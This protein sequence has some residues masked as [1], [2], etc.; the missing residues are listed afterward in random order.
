M[1]LY[2]HNEEKY[3]TLAIT[4][5]KKNPQV[6]TGEHIKSLHIEGPVPSLR[7]ETS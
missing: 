5:A 6:S 4:L 7:S 3:Q 1:K 2:T